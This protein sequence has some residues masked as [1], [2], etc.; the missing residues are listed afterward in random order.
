MKIVTY[1]IHKG[2]DSNDKFTLNKISKY[3]KELD[4]DVICLQEVL[5]TQFAKLKLELKMDGVFAANVNKANMMYG[6]CTFSKT[7]ID[8]HD[9]VLLSSKKEQRGFLYTNIFSR[10]G[11][12]NVINTHLGLDL[13][14]RKQQLSEIIDYTNSLV[15]RK[16]ICGDFNEKNI[17]IN[18]FYDMA[19]F[20]NEYDLCTFKETNSRIDYVFVD[21]MINIYSYEIDLINY[22]DHYPVIGQIR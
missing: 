22:S 15:G 13:E 5:Y 19:I 6:I 4:C 9:H 18:T 21:K 3:L 14:E 12:F 20:M 11:K 16:I 17:S 10:N 7:E 1:N 8:T 2:M